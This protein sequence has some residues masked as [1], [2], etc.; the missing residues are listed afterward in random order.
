MFDNNKISEG[1]NKSYK[2]KANRQN[3]KNITAKS[4]KGNVKGTS[5]TGNNSFEKVNKGLNAKMQQNKK[6]VTEISFKEEYFKDKKYLDEI[7][8]GDNF[9]AKKLL[10][11]SLDRRKLEL[12]GYLEQGCKAHENKCLDEI[13]FINQIFTEYKD[14]ILDLQKK[15][16]LGS[17]IIQY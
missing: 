9:Q 13:K 16:L 6:E 14:V 12:S 10:I 2:G 7:F 17:G 3:Y 1:L 8:L 15:R 4:E 11:E 5:F